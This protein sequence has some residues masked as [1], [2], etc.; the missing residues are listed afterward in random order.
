[1]KCHTVSNSKTSACSIVG[2]L[3]TI[4]PLVPSSRF[5]CLICRQQRRKRKEANNSTLSQGILQGI[6]GYHLP[7]FYNG[8]PFLLPSRLS[9]TGPHFS[10]LQVFP[11]M[12]FFPGALWSALYP[13]CIPEAGHF[14]PLQSN[15][16]LQKTSE[17]EMED[18]ASPPKPLHQCDRTLPSEAHNLV[19]HSS[20]S[21][22]ATMALPSAGRLFCKPCRLL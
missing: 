8:P 3:V 21:V 5:S 15:L 19:Q 4:A 17:C 16:H 12:Q 22:A 9:H 20:A 18:S 1:M 2:P 10:E 6:P 13:P 11:G 14:G 7:T